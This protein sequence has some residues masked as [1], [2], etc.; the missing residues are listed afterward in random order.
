[1]VP[2]D[3][4]DQPMDEDDKKFRLRGKHF[5]LTYSSLEGQGV[6]SD[7][8]VS[9]FLAEHDAAAI[10]AG[11]EKHRDG[12]THVHILVKLGHDVDSTDPRYFDVG[13]A[14]PNIQRP[15]K[16]ATGAKVK[17][18]QLEKRAYTMKD[19]NF[20]P[21]ETDPLSYRHMG[22]MLGPKNFRNHK[23]DWEAFVK[24]CE[25][26]HIKSPYPFMLMDGTDVA[27]PGP[28]DKKCGYI[29]CGPS[30]CGKTYHFG[31]QFKGKSVYKPTY[32]DH[33]WDAYNQEEIVWFDD[34]AKI[35]RAHVMLLIECHQ[36]ATSIGARYY[37]KSLPIGRRTG[38]IITCNRDN[39]PH[40]HSDEAIRTRMHFIDLYP[41]AAR[42]TV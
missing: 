5:F 10:Q 37:N 29:I 14:H 40:W 8:V 19:G 17:N 24:Q 26:K 27:R 21:P 3:D 41:S 22:F 20:W 6:T 1:M 39:L 42:M 11:E 18:W 38:V 30:N 12:T 34:H 31:Q 7:V 28:A 32:G 25:A 36:V 35:D 2:P 15:P 4:D 33:M 13:A 9:S 23:A 16:K